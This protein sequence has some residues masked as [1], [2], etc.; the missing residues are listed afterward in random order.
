MPKSPHSCCTRRALTPGGTGSASS[1]PRLREAFSAAAAPRAAAVLVL[2]PGSP[3]ALPSAAGA[4]P[5]YLCSLPRQTSGQ[6]SLLRP[7]RHAWHGLCSAPEECPPP[8]IAAVLVAG[9]GQS[10]VLASCSTTDGAAPVGLSKA[11]GGGV[12]VVG[13]VHPVV[14]GHVHRAAGRAEAGH[15]VEPAL[16]VRRGLRGK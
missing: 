14:E 11:G 10:R 12:Q 16:R 8:G 9:A 4:P 7:G 13:R 6:Y 1:R 3:A 2:P 15:L 5:A